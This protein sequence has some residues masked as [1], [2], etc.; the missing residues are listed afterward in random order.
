MATAVR[1]APEILDTWPGYVAVVVMADGVRNGPSDE[2]SEGLLADAERA[3]L[4]SGLERA[5]DDPRIGAWRRAFSEFGAKP[6]RYPSSAESLVGR[7]LK[8]GS[9]PRINALVDTY[10]AVSVRHLI[11]VGGEDLDRLQGHLRLVRAAGDERFD[12]SDGAIDPPRPGEVVWRDDLG[13]TCRRWNWRQ[14]SRTQLTA[15]T[16]R[17]F[18]VFDRLPPLAP[19]ALDAAVDEL[20]GH[21]RARSPDARARIERPTPS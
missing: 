17:A 2:P 3:V 1:V 13:V 19:E 21:L 11:P 12:T 4:G 6:S 9:L 18:F 14:G 10:N 7:V 16:E 15:T 20:V 5:A 8:G